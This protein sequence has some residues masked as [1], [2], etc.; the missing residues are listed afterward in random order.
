MKHNEAETQSTQNGTA[1][2]AEGGKRDSPDHDVTDLVLGAAVK[3]SKGLGCGFL[4]RVYENALLH[5]LQKLG[6]KVERQNLAEVHWD[7]IV[8]GTYQLDL[9]VEGWLVIELKA[10]RSLNDEHVAQTVNYLKATHQRLALLLNF[11]GPK[12][13]IRRL[14]NSNN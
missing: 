2:D 8:V 7:G 1:E 3:I 4:E 11:G 5:E 9:L 6:L 10:C 13:Q 12:L 14:I